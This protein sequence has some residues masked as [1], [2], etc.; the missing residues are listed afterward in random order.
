MAVAAAA[1]WAQPPTQADIT[2]TYSCRGINSDGSA[3]HGVVTIVR[4]A[5]ADYLL[6][7]LQPAVTALGVGIREG[8]TLGISYYGPNTGIIVYRIDGNQLIGRWTMAGGNALASET[9]TLIGEIPPGGR[10]RVQARHRLPVRAGRFVCKV[11]LHVPV[12]AGMPCRH[13]QI[14]RVTRM[15]QPSS[16]VHH[17]LAAIVER[18]TVKRMRSRLSS[19]K[20]YARQ[21]D[22]ISTPGDTEPAEPAPAAVVDTRVAWE[23][24][25]HQTSATVRCV[26]EEYDGGHC[27]I[28]I[29]HANQEIMNCWHASRADA[30][31]RAAFIE[32]DLRHTGWRAE[33]P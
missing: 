22:S 10:A 33:Q 17:R 2:G 21:H 29:S 16:P 6:W 7:E 31:D 8:D 28:R 14:Y 15:D 19:S 5:D 1:A 13:P 3:Y 4:R 23:L 24:R 26:I 11:P 27:L 25:S 18:P 32:T 20:R 9:L 30:T 12:A